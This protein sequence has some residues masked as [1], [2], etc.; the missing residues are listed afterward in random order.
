MERLLEAAKLVCAGDFHIVSVLVG[1][2]G[3][4]GFLLA[5]VNFFEQWVDNISYE[6]RSTAAG[7]RGIGG[8][9]TSSART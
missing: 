2:A 4:F 7:I 8:N 6:S 3:I 1:D 9:D 5:R